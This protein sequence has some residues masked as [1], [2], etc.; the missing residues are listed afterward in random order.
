[1]GLPLSAY[2]RVHRVDRR[3]YRL[4]RL[5]PAD[6]ADVRVTDHPWPQGAQVEV[7][8]SVFEAAGRLFVGNVQVITAPEPIETPYG[9]LVPPEVEPLPVGADLMRLTPVGLLADEAIHAVAADAPDSRELDHDP[10]ARARLD[11]AVRAGS[12]DKPRRGR[13]PTLGPELLELVAQA[14]RAGGRSGVRSVQRALTEDARFHGEATWDQA[15]KGVARARAGL[16]PKP[17][18][19]RI[20]KGDAR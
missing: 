10:D 8:V 7:R 20:T 14:Y 13:K 1:M 4:E 15:A 2:F 17:T 19:S 16:L 5:R 9:L 12:A 11:S 6:P 18:A 3:R